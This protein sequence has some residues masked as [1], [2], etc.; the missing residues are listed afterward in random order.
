MIFAILRYIPS[1][2]ID[3]VADILALVLAPVAACFVA[4]IDG[5]DHIH[6]YWRWITT[7][8]TTVDA[9]W[10]GSYGRDGWIKRRFTQADYDRSR[11]LRWACRVLWIW[12]NPA[13]QV[14]HW[15][16]FDQHAVQRPADRFKDP[17]WDT[18]IPNKAFWK[19]KNAWRQT[20]FLYQRQINWGYD[21]STLWHRLPDCSFTLEMQ[22]GWKLYRND[23]DQRCMLAFR[24]LPFKRY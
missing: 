3:L 20:G 17:L 23:P 12:R 22:F 24:F 8:D 19:V 6:P 1:A 16:G 18:G 14:A 2:I 15:L 4:R 21:F 7:H 5:R 10:R 13:Y 11:V 9:W